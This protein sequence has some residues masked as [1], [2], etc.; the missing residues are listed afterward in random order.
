MLHS[1]IDF[2]LQIPGYCIVVLALIGTG[3]AQSL[4]SVRKRSDA[5]NMLHVSEHGGAM[6][7]ASELEKSEAGTRAD[8]AVL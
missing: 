2:S 8:I 4:G 3:L 6:T 5:T 1:L 7:P